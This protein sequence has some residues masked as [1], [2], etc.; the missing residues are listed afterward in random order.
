M[1]LVA[2]S[3]CLSHAAR[4]TAHKCVKPSQKYLAVASE[5]AD[6]L[7]ATLMRGDATPALYGLSTL[8]MSE[9]CRRM[10]VASVSI[11]A[12]QHTTAA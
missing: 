11:A 10:S 9:N 6:C 1:G 7:D 8:E 12:A 2:N 3:A 5:S 4:C